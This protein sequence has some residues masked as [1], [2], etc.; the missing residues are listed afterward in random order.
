M[1]DLVDIDLG[2]ATLNRRK[3]LERSGKAAAAAAIAAQP[4]WLAACGSSSSHSGAS[5][6]DWS[7]LAKLLHGRLLTPGGPGYSTS[8]LPYNKLY[9]S[10]RPRGI[11]KCAD[12]SD[13]RT[14]LLWAEQAGE[15]FTVMSGGHSYAGF[16]TS[17]GLVIDMSGLNTLTFDHS[18]DQVKIGVG[19]R[20]HQLFTALPPLHVGLPH[21]RC[22][23]TGVGGFV[24]GGG[25]G[26]TSRT[27][28]MLCDTLVR[29]ELITA[30]GDVL[31]CD[32][33]QNPDLYWAS[34]GGTGGNFGINT[35]YTLQ[36]HPLPDKVSVYQ[37]KWPWA[38]AAAA[39]AALQKM[40]LNGPDQL[41]CRIGL[42]ATGL[43]HKTFSAETLGEYVGPVAHLR[44]LLAPVLASAKATSVTIKEVPLAEGIKFLAADVPYDRFASKS[45]YA[46]DPF[47][48]A[49]LSTLVRQLD[50]IPGSSNTGGNGIA[51]FC[52]GGAVNRVP[53][54]ATAYVHRTA[55]FLINFEAT[56]EATD[57]PEVVSA[58]EHWLQSIYDSMQPYV[59]PN[60][61]QNWPDPTLGDWKSAYFGSNLKRLTQVKAKYDPRDRF[62]YA[63]SLPLSV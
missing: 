18:S 55:R 21:G 51:I 35:S 25:F 44:E 37:I 3:F 6:A 11:A 39:V 12:A 62:K 20:N 49:A 14:A 47:S 1:T 43:K 41:G 54:A 16:S 42:G 59:L 26:F 56:W 8:A 13:A 31:T 2:S 19:V 29:T 23:V 63:Q 24:L 57:T 27:M 50:R 60:S 28:G 40:M 38:D 58:N 36:T 17:R 22:P 30:T 9:T 53:T 7:K 45:S 10:V 4:A 52:L 61:Y 33:Q 34:R 48:D 32:A 46:V 5:N 15:E